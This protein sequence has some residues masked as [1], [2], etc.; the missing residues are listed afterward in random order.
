MPLY[1]HADTGERKRTVPG[2]HEDRRC[3]DDPKWQRITPQQPAATPSPTAQT[4]AEE[5]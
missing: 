4:A 1:E 3:A 5:A 2:R